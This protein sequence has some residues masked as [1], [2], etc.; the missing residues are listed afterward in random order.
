MFSKFFLIVAVLGFTISCNQKAEKATTE[1]TTKDNTTTRFYSAIVA[2]T[3][4]SAESPNGD[5]ALQ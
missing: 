2:D 4:V 1:I 5:S 3:S